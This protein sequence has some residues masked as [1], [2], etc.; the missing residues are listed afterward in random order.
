MTNR[1]LTATPLG[2]GSGVFGTVGDVLATATDFQ[3][4]AIGFAYSP[5]AVEWIR[6]GS[7]AWL[8]R[9]GE[10]RGSGS[11]FELRIFDGARELRWRKDGSAGEALMLTETESTGAPGERRRLSDEPYSRLVWGSTTGRVSE[12]R[13]W[14]EVAEGSRIAPFWVPAAVGPAG[15]P[16]RALVVLAAV[17]YIRTDQF[18]NAG[19]VDERLVSLAVKS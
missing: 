7:A 10:F 5:T 15:P 2:G 18:G 1:Q 17:E 9:A 19:V 11:E 16:T 12:D 6:R 14:V 13:K 3:E 8:T 4:G